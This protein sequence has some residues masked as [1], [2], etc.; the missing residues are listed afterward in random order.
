MSTFLISTNIQADYF[1]VSEVVG[2][3]LAQSPPH[4]RIVDAWRTF[5]DTLC[6]ADFSGHSV[7]G[8]LFRTLC[9]WWS[10]PDSLCN[11]HPF[12]TSLCITF[13]HLIKRQLI[14]LPRIFALAS[15]QGLANLRP[16]YGNCL[17][18]TMLF[19][20]KPVYSLL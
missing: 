15:K 3:A 10:F 19:S 7:L 13:R 18:G 11:R 6:L 16:T 17:S 5:P 14:Y 1:S 9:A 4:F 12:Q 20:E 8:G 2:S